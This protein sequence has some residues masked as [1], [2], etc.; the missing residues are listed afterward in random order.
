MR[1]RLLLAFTVIIFITLVGI[2]LFIRSETSDQIRQFVRRGGETGVNALVDDLEETYAANNSWAGA[3]TILEQYAVPTGSGFG[4]G[5]QGRSEF[6]LVDAAGQSVLSEDDWV[7]SRED[8]KQG[9]ELEVNN[10]VVGYLILPGNQTSSIDE[11]EQRIITELDQAMAHAAL[12]SGAAALILAFVLAYAF[13]KPIGQLTRAASS[14][15]KGNLEERVSEKGTQEVKTLAK[16]FNHMAAALQTAERNRKAL[17]A[18]IAHELRTPLAVQKINLEAL[19]DGVY[20]LTLEA[21]QPIM[22]QND[23]LTRLVQDLRMLS[24]AEAGELALEKTDFELLPLLRRLQVQFQQQAQQR[25]ISLDL[26]P[27]SAD[28]KVFADPTRIAQI[29]S[30]LLQNALRYTPAGSQVILS[31]KSLD[32]QVEIMVR[33]TGDGIPEA[34]LAYV[35][36]RFY[37]ADKSRSRSEGGSGLGLAIA[38]QLAE[39]NGGRLTAENH[40]AGGAVFTLTLPKTN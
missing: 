37:K 15:A 38:R 33:D 13:V 24:L 31:C 11:Q 19:Q 34:E 39:L 1:L 26:S 5:G 16:A 21:L 10:R 27:N 12:I 14:L 20:P 25:Q 40:A 32:N 6:H 22:D 35:F 29:L 2:S 36:E 3:Q 7:T 9:I 4:K 23:F 18:D 17:T 8:L 28:V 30:N